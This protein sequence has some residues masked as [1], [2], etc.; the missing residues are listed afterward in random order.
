MVLPRVS[1]DLD[2]PV[3]RTRADRLRLVDDLVD[4]SD[5][6]PREPPAA[7]D[8]ASKRPVND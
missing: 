3:E 7:P 8:P 2:P 1:P 5:D 6:P 4:R